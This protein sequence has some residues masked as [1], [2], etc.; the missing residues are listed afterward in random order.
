MYVVKSEFRVNT[1]ARQL[2]TQYEEEFVTIFI[3]SLYICQHYHDI[4]HSKLA[5]FD[6]FD[7]ML[8]PLSLIMDFTVAEFAQMLVAAEAELAGLLFLTFLA[9]VVGF[10][11]VVVI[12]HVYFQTGKTVIAATFRAK[13]HSLGFTAFTALH[14][15][16]NKII[17]MRS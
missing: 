1:A 17:R 8:G 7:N 11:V 4:T 9:E 14:V 15:F 13:G 16:C 12:G 5:L 10:T 6:L 3:E 2:F